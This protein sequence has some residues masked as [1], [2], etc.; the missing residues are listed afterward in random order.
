M[1]SRPRKQAKSR[2]SGRTFTVVHVP[3]CSMHVAWCHGPMSTQLPC[4]RAE[5]EGPPDLLRIKVRSSMHCDAHA[6]VE[7]K[8]GS[9]ASL[10]PPATARIH[11]RTL[12][13]HMQ[14]TRQCKTLFCIPGCRTHSQISQVVRELKRTAYKPR[15]SIL[16]R[17]VPV[18]ALVDLCS[19][20]CTLYDLCSIMTRRHQAT[21]QHQF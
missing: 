6:H 10:L 11:C 7:Q 21:Q 17:P 1:G 5:G 19:V 3:C 13:H 14:R 12:A 20:L 18:G 8:R 9:W 2:R 15:I 4:M 16:V